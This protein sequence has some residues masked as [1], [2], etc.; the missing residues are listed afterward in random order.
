[1]FLAIW[2]LWLFLAKKVHYYAFVRMRYLFFIGLFLLCAC[3]MPIA[4]EGASTVSRE[5]HQSFVD[6]QHE[7]LYQ[8]LLGALNEEYQALALYKVVLAEYG[9]IRP[10]P[11]ITVAQSRHVQILRDFLVLY[12]Q[13]V[14]H[15][16]WIVSTMTP[17][18]LKEACQKALTHEL[19]SVALYQQEFIPAA[20]FFPDVQQALMRLMQAS[21]ESHLPAFERC[22]ERE[23]Q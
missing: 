12:D 21:R 13:S 20:A 11:N 23:T 4:E 18:S 10:F 7:Q 3:Q 8:V 14:P 2:I 6:G 5:E 22:I 15:N 19:T 1:M 16:R 17:S 9:D